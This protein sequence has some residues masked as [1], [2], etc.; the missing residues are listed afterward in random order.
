MTLV[1]K[2]G[3]AA[4]IDA[5]PVL[6]DL[7]RRQD[8]VLVHGASDAASMLGE[9]LGHPPRFVTSASGHVSR[10][11]DAETLDVFAM[12]SGQRNLRLV[13]A[14]QRLGVNAVGLV[15][16]SGR[17]LEGARKDHVKA[18]VDGKRVVLRGDHTG[19]V[20]RVNA[21]LL[22][23]LL[24]SGYAPVLTVPAISFEGDA[25]NADADRAAAAVAGAL[26]AET[27]VVLSNVPGLLRDLQDP[28]SLVRRIPAAELEGLAEKYAQ[29][30]F[31]KKM[32]GAAEALRLGVRRVVLASAGGPEPVEAALR[33]EGT[34]IEAA[35]VEAVP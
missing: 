20:E 8:W 11:T 33:G 1:V 3:G 25:V 24:A 29:G 6:R 34:V 19:A 2:V 9:R 23:L 4:G 10:F 26:G 28:A 31:K 32:L 27:L 7:A 16:V 12:A 18:I 17:L 21:P 13:E 5:Q 35:G 30:R 14:L 22:R 15:G